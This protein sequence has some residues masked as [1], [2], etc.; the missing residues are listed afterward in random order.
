[1]R[2]KHLSLILLVLALIIIYNVF[3]LV[4][5]DKVSDAVEAQLS[6]DFRKTLPESQPN[7]IGH[8]FQETLEKPTHQKTANKEEKSD[9]YVLQAVL[10]DQKRNN[11]NNKNQDLNIEI[12]HEDE[13]SELRGLIDP[14]K[15]DEDYDDED[16]SDYEED[17]RSHKKK[18]RRYP[19][20]LIIGSQKSGTTS[21]RK[22]LSFHPSIVT[23]TDEI[24][25]FDKYAESGE[26]YYWY[27]RQM[28]K[29]YDTQITMEKTPNYLTHPT[30]AGLVKKYQYFIGKELKFILI[31]RDPIRRTISHAF[32]A[33]RHGRTNL[34]NLTAEILD[35]KSTPYLRQS[36]YG[37]HFT[38][39]LQLFKR[40]QFLILDG[41]R[42]AKENPTE[43][44]KD[45]ENFLG[46]I[47]IYSESDFGFSDDKGFY[48]Y[49]PTHFCFPKN[50]GHSS[51]KQSL[52]PEG[53]EILKKTF[54][55]DLENFWKLSGVYY[56]WSLGSS[57]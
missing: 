11:N 52:T 5:N 44:L 47:N 2:Q 28:P 37:K 55:A 41:E 35:T 53:K 23:A 30:S 31:V 40:E 18:A 17:D 3:Q 26:N 43:I 51:Y 10:T 14:K 50:R 54:Q 49:R 9:D 21:L 12:S 48:C 27:L 56:N 24:H 25:Y 20:V 36:L 46:L 57:V 15:E 34:T 8:Q 22:F 29:S 33:Q 6:R 39:W 1:M 38:R 19:T 16:E 45:V 32:H 42:F 13:K 4:T 7:E